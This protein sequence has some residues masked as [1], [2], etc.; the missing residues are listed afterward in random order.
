MLELIAVI[1]MTIDHIGFIFF[2]DHPLFRVIGRIA[3]PLY[4]W[5]VVQGY[6]YTRSKVN[7]VSRLVLLAVI[8]QIPYMLLFHFLHLNVIFTLMFC[9]LFIILLE[10]DKSLF[11]KIGIFLLLSIFLEMFCEYGVYALLLTL[12]FHTTKS[13]V[14]VILLFGLLNVL[15]MVLKGN[16][17]QGFSILSLFFIFYKDLFINIRINRYFYRSY[18]PVHITILFI[19]FYILNK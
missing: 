18:Y 13:R 5:G 15:F 6:Q 2:P 19:L 12:I 1:T 4:I 7:Y 9:L 11:L 17:I 10:S 16:Y 14:R 3:F 8:S